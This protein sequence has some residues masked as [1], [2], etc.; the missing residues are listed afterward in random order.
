VEIDVT[1]V[2]RKVGAK[3]RQSRTQTAD[4]AQGR[5][6]A[7]PVRKERSTR[8]LGRGAKGKAVPRE[9]LAKRV[10][11]I[12]QLNP[13]QKCG[14]GTTVQHLF[15]VDETK[16]GLAATHLVFFDRHGWYCEHGRGCPAVDDVRKANRQ[17]T[18]TTTVG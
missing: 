2:K 3:R 11:R 1:K 13:V 4:V 12:R 7:A 17:L 15:R 9:P 10:I 5:A 8:P 14:A 18:R 16:D 6:K